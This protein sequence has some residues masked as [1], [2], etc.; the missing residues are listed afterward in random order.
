MKKIMLSALFATLF[1]VFATQAFALSDADYYKFMREDQ[2]FSQAEKKLD[3]VWQTLRA[4]LSK[5]EYQTVLQE[6]RVWIKSGRDAAAGEH[7]AYRLNPAEAYAAAIAARAGSLEAR[8]LPSRQ[9]DAA[10]ME[11]DPRRDAL[12]NAS[13]RDEI[14]WSKAGAEGY[15]FEVKNVSSAANSPSRPAPARAGNPPL[16]GK[17]YT[18]SIG[19]EFVL[20]PAGSFMM[21][22]PD[23]EKILSWERPQHKVNISKPFYLGKYEVTQEQ[24]EAVMG[25][26]PSWLK[27]R[28]NPVELVSWNDTQEFIRRLNAREGHGRYRLPTEAE[29]EYAARAGTTTAYSFGDDAGNLGRYAWCTPGDEA[30]H[31]VGQKEANAWGLHDMHGNVHEWVQDWYDKTYYSHSPET[32]PLGPSTGSRRVIRGGGYG[33]AAMLCRSSARLHFWPKRYVGADG[34]FRLALSPE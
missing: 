20:V 7:P 32:D 28:T 8:Y 4:K 33:D 3:E 12:A 24:W 13:G 25:N 1:S 6:Q 10:R 14:P 5:D 15:E 21:G 23:S 9:P 34:G 16:A 31:P 29:W 18:N 27:G 26:N 2:S 17:T 19:M 11:K 22:A 30:H